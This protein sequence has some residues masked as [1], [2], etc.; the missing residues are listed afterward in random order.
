MS[1]IILVGI[2]LADII[3]H[4][5]VLRSI[6]LMLEY[7]FAA[8]F[9]VWM[10]G[11]FA[12]GNHVTADGLGTYSFNLNS[13]VNPMGWSCIFKELPDNRSTIF[14]RDQN[15][16]VSS[17]VERLFSQF[18]GRTAQET[19]IEEYCRM[20]LKREMDMQNVMFHF[21]YAEEFHMR[22]AEGGGMPGWI[23]P[24]DSSINL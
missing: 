1:G 3:A 11:G 21:V 15:Q 22:M 14:Y 20:I 19:E 24:H 23:T 18:L 12:D 2:C 13:F 10:L 9:I 4:K 8:A 17:F 5:R 6:L 16:F 7:I